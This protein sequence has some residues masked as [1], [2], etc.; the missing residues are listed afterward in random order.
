MRRASPLFA[1]IAALGLRHGEALG[2]QWGDLD[3]KAGTLD[4]RRTVVSRGGTPMIS[5]PKTRSA[6]RTLYLTPALKTVLHRHLLDL[7][8]RD[9][10]TDASA[11]VFPNRMGGMLSQHNVRRVW[12]QA[13]AAAE[14]SETTRIHDLRHTFVSRLI[15][16]GADPRTAADLAGHADPRMTLSVY[17]HTRAEKRKATLLASMT[18]LDELLEAEG[19]P[20][21]QAVGVE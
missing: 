2:L 19:A 10:P 20:L 3:W 12:R 1:I 11:W 17:T 15:E 14:V 16:G 8:G 21:E 18:H 6:R 4:V 7:K 13:L 5:E 9:L